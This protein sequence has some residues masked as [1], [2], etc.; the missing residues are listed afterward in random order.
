MFFDGLVWL[1]LNQQHRI[2][3]SASE[4]TPLRS[5]LLV[6]QQRASLSEYSCAS[7]SKPE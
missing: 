6:H 1:D 7:D 3:R 5:H 4:V 2:P